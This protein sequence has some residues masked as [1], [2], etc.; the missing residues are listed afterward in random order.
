MKH[1]F[2]ILQLCLVCS[3]SYAET[4]YVATNGSNSNAGTIN[5]PFATID[6]LS[7]VMVAGDIAY[8][9]GGTYR[10]TG[11]AGSSQHFVLQ[12]LNGSAGNPI[13]IWAYPGEQPVFNLDNITPTNGNPT[14]FR[15]VNSKYIHLKGIRITGLKQHTGGSGISRGFHVENLTNST[16][17]LVEVDHIGG[18]GFYF[19]DGANYNTFLNCDAHHIDDRYSGWGNGNGFDCSG[20][21][22]A[23]GNVFEG[24]R[25]W[26]CSDDGFDFYST[27]GVQTLKN[28]WAFWNGYEPGTF[29]PV[30]DGDG[31]KLGPD[32][33]GMHNTLLR[34]LTNCVSFE[35]KQH[36]FNQNVGDMK[37]K[38]YNNT[39]FKNGQ[40]GYMWD[41]V[42]P[43]PVQD[44]KNNIS[45]MDRTARRGN[46][47]NGSNNSWNGGVT[48][49]NS[50]FLRMDNGSP[51]AACR[52]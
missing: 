9:R 26:W 51:T 4:Y 32:A 3:F 40:T 22:N 34:T 37:V 27:N 21:V 49:N 24:C 36:G 8:I 12:N 35:N 48:V 15:L 25:V 38:L 7:S 6:K 14:A 45:Y 16:I 5:A 42:S 19:R 28:C 46:E 47:T 31:F 41:F 39:S 11:N 29:N 20:G 44:F 33:G 17:E 2:A 18:Y 50:D 1:F 30:G 52:Y 10:T 23:T 43:A 13:K